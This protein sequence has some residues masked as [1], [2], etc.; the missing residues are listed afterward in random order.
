V[1]YQRHHQGARHG[2]AKTR[3]P[4]RSLV[5]SHVQVHLQAHVHT[6]TSIWTKGSRTRS[7]YRILAPALDQ[8]FARV[9]ISQHT[10]ARVVVRVPQRKVQEER[11]QGHVG[12]DS[13]VRREDTGRRATQLLERGLGLA[14]SD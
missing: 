3:Q 6:R 9:V 12:P 5:P 10:L 1:Q 13:G 11:K 4:Q 2:A 8:P 7:R 14:W